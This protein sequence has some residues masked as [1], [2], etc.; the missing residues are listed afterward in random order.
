M[1]LIMHF[2][3]SVMVSIFISINALFRDLKK[4]DFCSKESRKKSYCII[5]ETGKGKEVLFCF[6]FLSL[7]VLELTL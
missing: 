1:P 3:M 7:A 4:I 6:Y 5:A 2:D